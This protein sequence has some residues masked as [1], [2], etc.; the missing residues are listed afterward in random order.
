MKN[1]FTYIIF[2]FFIIT[3]FS[4]CNYFKEKKEKKE[5]AER[6]I[7]LK[8][9][10][11]TK[12]EK[13]TP[14]L[15]FD[16][17]TLDTLFSYE[18]ENKLIYSN[19]NSVFRGRILDI[20]NKDS[21]TY[22]LLVKMKSYSY[23]EHSYIFRLIANQTI[24]KQIKHGDYSKYHTYQFI[25]KL[26]QIKIKYGFVPYV[27]DYDIYCNNEEDCSLEDYSIGYDLRDRTYIIDGNLFELIK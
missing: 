17:S 4:S 14:Y 22:I 26:N 9:E 8:A 15:F 3:L 2:L 5:R 23:S 10:F 18:I 20:Q 7:Q 27:Q 6:E 1:K 21:A 13:Y 11:E 16:I 19:K 24:V 12:V 25:G